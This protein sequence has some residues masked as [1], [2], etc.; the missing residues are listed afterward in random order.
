MF[1]LLSLR[2]RALLAAVGLAI[3]AG[4]PPAQAAE[5]SVKMVKA[6][7]TLAAQEGVS[8]APEN[9]VDHKASTFWV[10]GEEA[11]GLGEW[12]QF[13]FAQTET[14]SR[15]EIRPGNW[16]SQDFWSR[17]NRIKEVQ[18]KFQ[19]GAPLRFD[20]TDKMETQVLTLDTPVST[21]FV[22]IILKGVYPGSTFNDTCLSEVRFF[23][24]ATAVGEVVPKAGKAS[25]VYPGFAA[26][27]A[28]DGMVDTLW[29]EKK[30]GDGTGEW[31]E[32]TLPAEAQVR[33]VRVVVGSAATEASY[34]HNNRASQV[35]VSAGG[36]VVSAPL[37]DKFAQPQEILFPAPVPASSVKLTVEKVVRGLEYNDTCFAEIQVLTP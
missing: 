7:S 31:I 25:S 13:D 14:V 1:D 15:I 5:L 17:H 11:A 36:A 23:N 32:L 29:C 24:A 21:R 8:Y 2:W 34:I 30:D 4:P 35:Q 28:F 26:A 9:T 19:T 18:L 33:G 37:V 22:R 3:F 6:S 10:E 12:I 27:D 20:L 16:Y